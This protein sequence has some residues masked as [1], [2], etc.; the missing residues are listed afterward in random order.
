MTE[1]LRRLVAW[2]GLSRRP[3]QAPQHPLYGPLC[4]VSSLRYPPLPTHRSPYR[5]DA[6]ID[7]T[8]TVA[9]RPYLVVHEQRQQCRELGDLDGVEAA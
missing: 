3:R 1:L 8:S 2:V 9:A 4:G 7:G 5:S 6:F